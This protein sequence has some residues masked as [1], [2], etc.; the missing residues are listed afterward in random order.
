M[1]KSIEI[2]PH[3]QNLRKEKAIQKTRQN[4]VMSLAENYCFDKSASI[5]FD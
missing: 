5:A 2:Y 4:R 1:E 3:L